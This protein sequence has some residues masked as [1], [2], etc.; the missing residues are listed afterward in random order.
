MS[1][2]KGA[3]NLLSNHKPIILLSTHGASLRVD[4]LEFLKR[5]KYGQIVPLN[6]HEIDRASEFAIIP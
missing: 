1:V 4:C 3:E 6:S 2:L 5:M